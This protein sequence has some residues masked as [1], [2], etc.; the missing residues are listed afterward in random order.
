[1]RTFGVYTEKMKNVKEILARNG[2]SFKKAFGQNFI[3]DGNLLKDI[4]REAGIGPEDTVLEIGCGAGTLTYELSQTAKRVVGYEIDRA[5][6]PVL[7][8]TL[9]GCSNVELC[10]SDVMKKKTADLEC[11]LGGEYKVVANLP[12][13]ITTPVIM[14]F[15]EEAKNV[16]TLV[17]MVQEEVAERLCVEADTPAYG[18]I[19][20]AVDLAGEAK[21]VRRV[22]RRM[23]FPAPKV[24]SA[25]VRLDIDRNRAAGVDCKIYRDV[26][27]AAFSSRR[28][29]LANN[30]MNS[31]SMTRTEAERLLSSCGIGSTVRGETL[32]AEKFKSLAK[33]YGEMQW[34]D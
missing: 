33:A 18:A 16:K 6:M 29:M 19:T 4:V 9:A 31:F 10:F 3:T 1:M 28:K 30:L 12:Y 8:E 11:E 15:V 23:F 20:A 32:S 7:G 21:I 24:D 13:Y 5:L 34:K 25:V 22:P 2:F 26:V 17:V 14:R 27:R